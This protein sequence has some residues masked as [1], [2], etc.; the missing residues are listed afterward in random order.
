[1]LDI[2]VPQFRVHS[3]SLPQFTSYIS[4]IGFD[5]MIPFSSYLL[6][7]KKVTHF[8]EPIHGKYMRASGSLVGSNYNEL[9][10]CFSILSWLPSHTLPQL[11]KVITRDVIESRAKFEL[12]LTQLRIFLFIF[13]FKITSFASSKL[14]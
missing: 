12:A 4:V 8:H 3:P 13:L 2:T 14:S 11:C 7:K 1:M 6:E 5:T 9:F 10:I